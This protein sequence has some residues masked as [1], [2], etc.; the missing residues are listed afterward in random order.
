MKNRVALFAFLVA[1][2]IAAVVSAATPDGT[3]YTLKLCPCG[4]PTVYMPGSCPCFDANMEPALDAA[5]REAY[6]AADRAR[7]KPSFHPCQA[8]AA[9]DYGVTPGG[10]QNGI[11]HNGQSFGGPQP[12]HFDHPDW[13]P[14]PIYQPPVVNPWQF[15]APVIAN[16]ATAPR[17]ITN[18][19]TGQP[20]LMTPGS[21]VAVNVGTP[22]QT[23]VYQPLP[24][25]PLVSATAP[26]PAAPGPERVRP[27]K[28]IGRIG[29][30]IIHPFRK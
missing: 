23:Y 1:V 17:W 14:G 22:Q 8:P 16:I 26:Q 11:Y 9:P 15:V 24:I 29:K 12:P 20:Q 2:A 7:D 6:A 4:G 25:W 27:L 5:A 21:W 19:L 18:P 13:H 28:L 30:A 10:W 3:Y